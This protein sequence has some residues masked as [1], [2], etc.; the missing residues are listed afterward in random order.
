MTIWHESLKIITNNRNKRRRICSGLNKKRIRG[1]F[2]RDSSGATFAILIVLGIGA[3][4]TLLVFTIIGWCKIFKKA[5]IHPGKFFIPVYGGWLAWDIADCGGLYIAMMVVSGIASFISTVAMNSSLSM[6]RYSYGYRYNNAS[7]LN[8]ALVAYI[9]VL[10]ICI[11]FQIIFCCKLAKVFG[12]NGGFAAGLIFL[13]PI[14]IIILG[15]GSAQYLNKKGLD[16]IAATTETWK[17][18]YCGAVNPKSRMT[19]SACGREK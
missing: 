10:I 3:V 18:E 13:N 6:D 4:I 7:A 11:V 1:D 5:G 12:K 2:M 17:C 19:C 8:G 14:F 16:N 15:Y 9:I